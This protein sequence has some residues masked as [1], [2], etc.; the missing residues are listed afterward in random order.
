MKKLLTIAGIAATLACCAPGAK[1]SIGITTNW[2]PVNISITV[3]TN[4]VEKEPSTDVYTEATGQAKISNTTL[5]NIFAHW[6]GVSSWPAGAMLVIGWDEPWSGHVLV[7]DE[8][9]TNVLFD[10]DDTGI[11]D[12]YFYVEYG[13][14]EGDYS[15]NEV[16]KTLYSYSEKEYKYGE[17]EFE[18]D[19][20]YLP[21]T[22]LYGYGNCT[23][24]YT[25]HYTYVTDQYTTW[26]QT[27]DL[28]NANYSESDMYW[29]DEDYTTVNGSV[30][31]SGSGKGE[32]YWY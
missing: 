9:G 16:D 21:Y 25:Q 3:T 23:V 17:F 5:K 7:V 31:S 27:T 26:S 15:W 24:S 28:D 6:A 14:D 20:Y 11:T 12:T 30:N 19:D 2:T 1:A 18:D 4:G 32:D 29:L 8:S 13:E 10:T 22:E